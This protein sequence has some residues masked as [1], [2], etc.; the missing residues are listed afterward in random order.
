MRTMSAPLIALLNSSTQFIMVDLFTFEL[1]NGAVLRYCTAG[2]AITFGGNTYLAAPAG[3]TRGKVRWATGTEVDNLEVVFQ[4]DSGITVIGTPLLA[5]AVQ[6]LFDAGRV[7]VQRLFLSDW[8][9]P[10]DALLLFRGNVST[11]DVQRLQVKMTVKSD[12]E[13]LNIQMP[14]NLYQASCVHSLFDI[15]C[16]VNKATYTVTGTVSS[17]GGSGQIVTALAQAD[18]YFQMGA[19][20]FTSGPNTGLVRTVKTWTS[21]SAYVTS[22]FPYTIVAGHAFEITPGCDKLRLGDCTNKYSNVI[23][24]KGFEFIPVP[25][26]AA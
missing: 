11:V 15:G 19:I 13:R 6:G 9:T 12:L 17:V 26:T 7:T 3:L 2:G 5:A 1:A 18:G 25:E 16:A 23:N 4:S 8:V 22:P 21:A 14:M 20:K 10:V 24:F